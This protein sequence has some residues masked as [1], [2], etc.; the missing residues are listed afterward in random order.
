MQVTIRQ[1][2]CFQP[3]ARDT[4]G[5]NSK[6]HTGKPGSDNQGYKQVTHEYWF[7]ATTAATR[8]TWALLIKLRKDQNCCKTSKANEHSARV[9]TDD[10]EKEVSLNSFQRNVFNGTILDMHDREAHVYFRVQTRRKR[11]D[12]KENKL[13]Q[14][15]SSARRFSKTCFNQAVQRYPH[16]HSLFDSSVWQTNWCWSCCFQ[17]LNWW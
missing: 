11:P 4:L 10:T 7:A 8:N 15:N 2:H 14:N 12:T 6:G 3:G 16:R 5:Q 13:H 1:P 17:A 9:T